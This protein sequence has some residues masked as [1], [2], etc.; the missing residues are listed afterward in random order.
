MNL[1][2]LQNNPKIAI[3]QIPD[4]ILIQKSN[5]RTST[6][7][8]AAN[9]NMH[10]I[11]RFTTNS[12]QLSTAPHFTN[13]IMNGTPKIKS[14]PQIP[15]V[16]LIKS[17]KPQ[18]L[19]LNTMNSNLQIPTEMSSP[20][21]YDMFDTLVFRYCNEP[22]LIFDMIQT[23]VNDP[24]FKQHR[25]HSE[26]VAYSTIQN[27]TI[28]QIYEIMGKIYKYDEMTLEMYKNVEFNTEM[29][30]IYPN[31]D[32][33]LKLKKNDII[34][35]DMY[36]SENQLRQILI[37]CCNHN[38]NTFNIDNEEIIKNIKIYVSS[39]GKHNGWIWNKIAEKNNIFYH[40]GDNLHSDVHMAQQSGLKSTHYTMCS[41]SSHE[42]ILIQSSNLEMANFSR[43]IRLLNPHT[44]SNKVLYNLI[45]NIN[46]P[47]LLLISSFLNSTNKKIAFFLRDCYYLKMF[48]DALYDDKCNSTYLV[49]SRVCFNDGGPEYLNYFKSIVN[50]DTLLIDGYA[51]GK[52][53][54]NFIQ[55][56][57]VPFKPQVCVISSSWPNMYYDRMFKFTQLKE[58]E[59]VEC[60]NATPI[61][62]F[63]GINN[64]MFKNLPNEYDK[65]YMDVIFK[66]HM[67]GIFKLINMS[68]PIKINFNLNVID[69]LYMHINYKSFLE[70][71]PHM[72]V[73]KDVNVQK[74]NRRHNLITFHSMGQPYDEALNL[75]SCGKTFENLY[76]PYFDACTRYNTN[77]CQTINADFIKTYM[78]SYPEHNLHEHSRGCNHG[79][80][81]WKPFVIKHHLAQINTGEILIYQD[82]NF[83]R[84]PHYIEHLNEY[85][86]LVECMFD[87]I[88]SDVIIPIENPDVLKCKH[89]V[90]QHVFETIGENNAYYREFP[91]L[92][93]NRIFI[94]KSEISMK[95]V[96]EWHDLCL[97]DDL[98]LPENTT[99]PE[100]RWH[101]HDQAIA[102]VL[103]RKYIKHGLFSKTGVC[104]FDKILKKSNIRWINVVN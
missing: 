48:Y 29:C 38:K 85:K 23:S 82:S 67:I 37:N 96:N 24:N 83:I 34:V 78:N 7:T 86:P 8:F 64:N 97:I 94:R 44:D 92:N 15:N 65:Q 73:H 79:F 31:N 69:A 21:S 80:W 18:T 104:I 51:S 98:L 103:Y 17:T 57:N 43:Y 101:T 12:S 41:Y 88:N 6:Q 66:A 27:T 36:L 49:T 3:P 26:Q 25:M 13:R 81:R 22:H 20:I 93:A 62:S 87:N 5:R 102:S 16:I 61:G 84:H 75:T 55:T 99:E 11:M 19:K 60:L 53:L 42:N 68:A 50:A 100:L 89:H 14:T 47:V 95:F 77:A 52:S 76:F 59:I 32:L 54:N 40:I 28:H 63:V 91:L 74:F 4:V 33:F 1:G 58:W 90:K 72:C 35:S 30:N 2:S 45:A 56:N 39:G 10:D 46:I 9:D 70:G 71:L